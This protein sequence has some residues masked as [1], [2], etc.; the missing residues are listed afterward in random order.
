MS[1]IYFS[2][3]LHINHNNI[4]KY[5][6][7]P[8]TVEEHTNWILSIVNEPLNDDDVMYNLGDFMLGNNVK[9]PALKA[10]I[11]QLNGTWKFI[12]GNHDNI[13]KMRAACK[14]TPHTV[15]GEYHSF[16]HNNKKFV[17]CHYPIQSWDCMRY[18]SIHLHGHIHN[19]VIPYMKNRYNVCLDY[20]HKIYNINDFMEK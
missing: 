15:L 4:I 20:E 17:L 13:E 3:D 1:S 11:S 16:R 10:I 9:L 7:R 19:T 2:S 18:G 14:G 12:I 5:C 6:N 8:C